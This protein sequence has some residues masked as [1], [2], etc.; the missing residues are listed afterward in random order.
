MEVYNDIRHYVLG[1]K[2]WGRRRGNSCHFHGFLQQ[3]QVLRRHLINRFKDRFKDSTSQKANEKEVG[4]VPI[5]GG[6][7]SSLG[8]VHTICVIL[9]YEHL[10][11][12]TYNYYTINIRHNIMFFVIAELFNHCTPSFTAKGKSRASTQ[13]VHS[14]RLSC[15]IHGSELNFKFPSHNY[16]KA[17]KL[18]SSLQRDFQGFTS[19]VHEVYVK[20]I[21]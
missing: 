21:I 1:W 17:W 9:Y 3:L 18:L 8:T 20:E 4:R 7:T 19:N 2:Q 15:E 14:W 5:S 6:Q 13:V 11:I 12:I 16:P 10:L